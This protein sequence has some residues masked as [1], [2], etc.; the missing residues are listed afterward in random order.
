MEHSTDT[1][2][3]DD[4][5][6]LAEKNPY[7]FFKPLDYLLDQLRL[8][9]L[10]KL[11]FVAN[12]PSEQWGAERMWVK[13]TALDS[14]GL[15]A[16]TLE[17]QPRDLP[18]LQLGDTIRFE[19]HHILDF[20]FDEDNQ[21]PP[22]CYD[23]ERFPP[24]REYWERCIVDHAILNGDLKIEHIERQVPSE[25]GGDDSIVDSGWQIWAD[26]RG[27]S[28][29]DIAARPYS[30]VALGVV[31]NKDD[32]WIAYIDC[33]IGSSFTRN[34]ETGLFAEDSDGT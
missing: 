27:S 5:R 15:L 11:T 30:Y 31:L 22:I 14:S 32:S 4:P 21:E 7:T 18:A 2:T 34:W 3:I 1:Y 19:R 12:P 6:P 17:N 9:D 13:I 29:E 16:G 23:L 33:P 28:E 10:V 26:T 20:R 8:G 25:A 24:P